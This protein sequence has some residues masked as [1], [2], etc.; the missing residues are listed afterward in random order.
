MT[1]LT[2]S[3]QAAI[4]HSEGPLLVIA[5]AGT[6]KTRVITERIFHM[7]DSGFA[8]TGEILALT[9]TEKATAEIES[10][11]DEK[12]PLGYEAIA[13]KT[14]HG[15]CDDLLRRY[16]VD[17]GLSPSFRLLQGV[18]QWMFLKERLFDLELDYYRPLSN[19]TK[20]IDA[21]L[22]HFSRLKEELISP[23]KYLDYAKQRLSKAGTP[24]EELEAKKFLELAKAYGKYQEFLMKAGALDFADLHYQVIELLERRPNILKYLQEKYKIILVDEYQDT[25]MA[26]NKLVDMLAARHKN[27]MVVGDDDQ[28]IYKF[29]GAAISNILQFEKN[30]PQAKKVVLTESFRSSQ[31]I[32]D[33]AYGSIQNNN[34]DRLEVTAKVDKKLKAS[35]PGDSESIH[36]VHCGTAEDEIDYV[37]GEIQKSKEPLSEIAIL[38]RANAHA[39]PYVE[40]LKKANIPYQFTSE[41][42]LYGKEE[43]KDLIAVLRVLSN[44][45]DDLSLF[46]IFSI[47]LFGIPM[48]KI[49]LLLQGAKKDYDSLYKAARRAADFKVP[50]QALEE[51][52]EFSRQHTVGET[53]YQFVQKIQLLEHWLK[54]GTLEA[55]EQIMNIASFFSK[56]KEFERENEN[57]RVIDFVTYLDLAEEAGENP[58][59]R[60]EVEGREGVHISSVHGAKGLEFHTVFV[61]SL[62]N[63]RFPAA[64]RQDPISIP[65]DLV[66]E[67]LSTG[68]EHLQEERRLFYVAI[69]RAKEK[70]HLLYS[71]FYGSSASLKPRKKKRSRFLDEM[72][73]KAQVTWVEKSGHE[74]E[75]FLKPEVKAATPFEIE[76]ERPKSFSYSQLGSFDTCPRQYQYQ[77]ILKI[78]QPQS[79]NMS[80]GSTMH[81][82]LQDY[83]KRVEQNKQSA[84]FTEF[85]PDTSLKSLLEIY[86]T[87]WIDQGYESK[88]HRDARKERGREILTKFY[89]KFKNEIPKIK[90]L[91][92]GFKLKIG[93]FT[94]TGRI[95]RADEKADGT[96]EII[97]YK[98]GATRDQK[99]VDKDLQLMLYALASSE[100]FRQQAS[101]LT[102]YFL[103][104]NVAVSTVPTD[105]ALEKAKL[106]VMEVAGRIQKSDFAPTPST[107]A[108]QHCPYNRI[109]DASQA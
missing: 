25:N 102:L 43:V 32:L 61:P 92:K 86:E 34:P 97:D 2:A 39:R 52:L 101:L 16:G 88:D 13:I 30:Y 69:T 36:V 12:M 35:R 89:D 70:L 7:V 68:D 48:E 72:A 38:V 100:V 66:S 73:E 47:P 49:V 83:Y 80:F 81:L 53:L 19:P 20:F 11:V 65:D 105:E 55:E 14:F 58:S 91:E 59:A 106:E 50:M 18:S 62:T 95:D 109:C 93:D 3:Q 33:F 45:T 37:L 74:V 23:V 90:F 21:L 41:K 64:N 98:T 46:R 42:G 63:D 79:A 9:F 82:T 84:L 104:E 96:L 17:I 26:Q 1:T 60:F 5:G 57:T 108:C 4:T 15:F 22:S 54:A 87:R 94:L 71:D 29:R 10:R 78:P 6:G 31:A 67:I 51:A 76:P 40:A 56:I 85:Q 24:E 8:K 99:Q 44:P 28:S 77:Y 75:R 27:L 107:F 103:D